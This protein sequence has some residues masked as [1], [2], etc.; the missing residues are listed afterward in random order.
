M[1][2][3]HSRVDNAVG[4]EAH[5]TA[6]SAVRAQVASSSVRPV[7]SNN[8]GMYHWQTAQ[9]YRRQADS[10]TAAIF[11]D[12]ELEQHPARNHVQL[13]QASASSALRRHD[14]SPE[15]CEHGSYHHNQRGL[16]AVEYSPGA[17]SFNFNTYCT[18]STGALCAIQCARASHEHVLSLEMT[19]MHLH[20]TQI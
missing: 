19:Q 4:N 2:V 11:Q 9:E 20:L 8:H 12:A 17:Q 18:Q 1:A 7:V 5:A 14:V 10:I 13:S 16:A 15:N 3:R 6:W